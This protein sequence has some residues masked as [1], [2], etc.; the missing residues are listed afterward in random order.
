MFMIASRSIF[1]VAVLKLLSDNYICVTLTLAS[2]DCLFSRELR[3]S[4]FFVCLGVLD[5]ILD[6]LTIM[7]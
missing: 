7:L 6:V 1:I 2:V 3:F 4:W 5:C